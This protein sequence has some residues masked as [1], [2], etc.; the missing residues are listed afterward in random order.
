MAERD[1]KPPPE[2]EQLHSRWWI[3]QGKPRERAV[4]KG[5]DENVAG[6][7]FF[8]VGIGYDQETARSRLTDLNLKLL[9]EGNPPV[10]GWGYLQMT[11][12]RFSARTFEE[13]QRAVP[14]RPGVRALA[15][16]SGVS[17]RVILTGEPTGEV[18]LELRYGEESSFDAWVRGEWVEEAVFRRLRD[19]LRT[20][21]AFVSNYFPG[22][23]PASG[24]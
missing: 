1:A 23:P 4:R 9:A 16:D 2:V 24:A 19:A 7:S 3:D 22:A 8:R 11:A 13:I 5:P 21:P 10:A 15:V 6:A 12:E 18:L 14:L 17:L 20:T